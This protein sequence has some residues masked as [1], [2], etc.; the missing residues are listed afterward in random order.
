MFAK[1][2]Q[3]AYFLVGAAGNNFGF[4]VSVMFEY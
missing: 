3:S 2:L 4:V 1:N